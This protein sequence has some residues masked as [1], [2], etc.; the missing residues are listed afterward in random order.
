MDGNSAEPVSGIINESPAGSIDSY[1]NE[2][3]DEISPSQRQSR[4]RSSRRSGRTSIIHAVRRAFSIDYERAES[5]DDMINDTEE[6]RPISQDGDVREVDPVRWRMIGVGVLVLLL[7]ATIA[8]TAKRGIGIRGKQQPYVGGENDI[9]TDPIMSLKPSATIEGLENGA[10]AADHPLCSQIGTSIMRD[11]GGN[12]IDAAV[13]V[14]LCLGVA[15]PASSGIGGGAFLLI[16]ADP[17]DETGKKMPVFRDARTNTSPKSK[18][19]KITEA[20]DCR[21]VAPG[22][23]FV[24]MFKD[25]PDDASVFGGL[26]IGVPGELRGLELAHARH[27]SLPWS[28]VVEPAMKLARDGVRVNA[29]LAHEINLMSEWFGDD[30]PD[31]GLRSFLTKNDSWNYPYG[32]GDLLRNPK[33]EETLRA[34][35]EEGSDALYTGKR[36][37]QLAKE[38]QSAGGIIT[39]EDIENFHATLR[40]PVAAHDMNGF[41]VVGVPPPSSGGAA[42]IGAARFLAGFESPLASFAETLSAHRFV[43]ACKHVFAVRMSMSDPAFNTDTVEEAVKDLTEGSYMAGLR[44]ASKDNSTLP[45]SQYGGEKWAQ[46]ED[47]DGK[48]KAKDAQE[49]D[50]FRR[51]RLARRFGYL[52][53][54]GTSHFSVVDKNGNAVAMTSSVNTYFGSNVFSSSTGIVLNNQMD[55][56]ASPGRPNFFGLHPSEANYITPGKKPLSSMSPTM[57]FRRSLA[58]QNATFG[59]LTLVVGASGGPKIITAVLQV[60]LNHIMRGLPL[61]ESIVHP[62]LHDQLI[63]HNAAVTTT[64][65]ATLEQG[66]TIDVSQRTRDALKRR[67][68]GLLDVDYAGTVQAVAVDLETKQLSA[69][70]DVRKGGSPDGY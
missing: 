52:N 66:P 57:I 36:A 10:V 44:K 7:L 42:I 33:L 31:F 24:D 63:Y 12:A 20:I 1:Q 62:R 25:E 15:N 69:A 3:L 28:D 61:F 37:A 22:A 41:S 46:L 8:A 26:A 29:N 32:E 21:E 35:M 51:R 9:C 23:A 48:G 39:K 49:G 18:S 59:D 70:C 64:E 54:H 56:F 68:H 45:M 2:N 53:D 55:D 65:L 58:S 60:L 38:I 43:E 11:N 13:A 67:G 16:H 50:R 5:D 14:A 6:F 27:G 34:I 47:S 19:G 17:A 30:D 40:S 4:G